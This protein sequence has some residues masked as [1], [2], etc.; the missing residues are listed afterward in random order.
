MVVAT[1]RLERPQWRWAYR[2]GLFPM[3]LAPAVA[4]RVA[5]LLGYRGVLWF[6]DSYS[7]LGVALRPQ[8]F[9]IRPVGYSLLLWLLHP[10]HSF[11]LVAGVQHALG[12]AVGVLLYALLRHRFRLPVWG[13][14]L[15]AAPVLLDGYQIELE[16]LLMSDVLFEALVMA[17]VTVVLWRR[18]PTVWHVGAA[19]LLFGLAGVTRSVGLPLIAVLLVYL[20]LARAGW[21]GRLGAAT[22]AALLFAVPVGA[23]TVWYHADRGHYAMSNSTGMFVYGRAA[24]FADCAQVK[25]PPAERR[26]CPDEPGG[27]RRAAPDYVWHNTRAFGH[28]KPAYKRFTVANDRAAGDF[29]RRAIIAQPWDYARASTRDL[30]R[31]FQ[32]SRER[33]PT[34]AT[35][36]HYRFPRIPQHMPHGYSVPGGTIRHDAH[37]Y[38]HTSGQ[39]T[40]V[41]PWATVIRGY[42]RWIYLHG[43]MFGAILLIGAVGL[44]RHR[45][46]AGGPALLPWGLAVALIVVPPFTTA[47][48]YRYVLPAVPLACLA[49]ALAFREPGRRAEPPGS[50]TPA[51]TVPGPP[52]AQAPGRPHPHPQP[53]GRP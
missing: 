15:A 35:V 52:P 46:T 38:G 30:L 41:T 3:L 40:I 24:S 28:S 13:A 9:P 21:R 1:V 33:Y 42:Q 45:R 25:P 27:H 6:P 53:A 4:L 7:Y 50:P 5:A 39:A 34:T 29:A 49:A 8:P 31:T 17:G 19:G 32:W 2:H 10:L 44:V 20:L 23:Y 47:F 22:V 36:T 11:M 18:R 48:D 26:F 43:T 37:R 14:S 16:H 51:I 12:L